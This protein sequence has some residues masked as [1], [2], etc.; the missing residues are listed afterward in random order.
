MKPET[1]IYDKIKN[2]VPVN[3][4]KN[5]FFAAIGE[6][7]FEMLFYSYIDN[8]PVQ[9]F[10]LAEQNILDENMLDETFEDI[11]NIIKSSKSYDDGKLNVVTITLDEKGI[12][13]S[14]EYYEKDAHLYKI[15]KEW[16]QS[17]IWKQIDGCD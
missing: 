8:K 10:D 6:T 2:I 7:S 5:I 13:M 15:K 16:K 11:T 1:L 9:C 12:K 17:L 14:V 4:D 3:S